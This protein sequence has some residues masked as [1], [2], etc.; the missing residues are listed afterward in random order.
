MKVKIACNE[1]YPIYSMG[2]ED[3]MLYEPEVEVTQ[4]FYDKYTRIQ[5]EYDHM[6]D[7]LRELGGG[8]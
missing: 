3:W 8:K 5:E 7:E 4:E 6:Q 2:N 1:A